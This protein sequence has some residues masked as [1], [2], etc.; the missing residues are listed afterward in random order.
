MAGWDL[1]GRMGLLLV[2]FRRFLVGIPRVAA[3]QVALGDLLLGYGHDLYHACLYHHDREILMDQ[4]AVAS[5]L[6]AFPSLVEIRGE[7]GLPSQA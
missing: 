5:H 3:F 2:P 7:V 6:A 1:Q 4:M